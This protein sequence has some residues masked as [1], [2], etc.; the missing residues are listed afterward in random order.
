ML[1]IKVRIITANAGLPLELWLKII[2]VAVYLYNHISSKFTLE[3]NSKELINPI[4]SFF[5]ELNINYFSL[6]HHIEYRHLRIYKYKIFI[7]IPKNIRMQSQKL[8]KRA[9]KDLLVDYKGNLIY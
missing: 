1:I 3:G 9:E 6:L 5:Q 8:A 7:Y 2:R 4:T